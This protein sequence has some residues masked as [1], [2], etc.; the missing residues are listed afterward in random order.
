[1]LVAFAAVFVI[2]TILFLAILGRKRGARWAAGLLLAEY[3]VLILMVTVFCR[4]LLDVREFHLIP[5][6]S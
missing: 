3:M 2:G 6:R 1:M 4:K 5:F